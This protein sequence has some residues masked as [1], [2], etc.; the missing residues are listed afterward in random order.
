MITNIKKTY[1]YN[2]KG[3]Y[4]EI[5][6]NFRNDNFLQKIKD[7]NETFLSY[8]VPPKTVFLSIKAAKNYAI[9]LIEDNLN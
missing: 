6:R 3:F 8:I 7:N 5:N 1:C 2:Y 4:F 9:Q